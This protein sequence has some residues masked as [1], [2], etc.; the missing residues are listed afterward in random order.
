MENMILAKMALGVTIALSLPGCIELPEHDIGQLEEVAAQDDTQ[1]APDGVDG[2]L[3]SNTDPDQLPPPED[4]IADADRLELWTGWTSEEYPPLT[5]N[6]GNV[7]RGVDCSGQYCDWVSLDCVSPGSATFTTQSWTSY[8]SEEG[9]NYR[10]CPSQSWLTG[11]ACKGSYCDD[12]SLKCTRI[13]NRTPT[14]CDWSGY[15]SEEDPPFVAPSG[16]YI[17]GVQC[18]GNYCDNKRYYHCNM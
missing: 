13:T 8:F 11:I 15:F 12:I 4:A 17:R 10:Y 5:C 3:G 2:D 14:N 6:T 9:T 16:K 7:A 1:P 18:G